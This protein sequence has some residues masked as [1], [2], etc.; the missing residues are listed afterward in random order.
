MMNCVVQVAKVKTVFVAFETL[1]APKGV[2]EF[3]EAWGLPDERWTK[4]VAALLKKEPSRRI[5]FLLAPVCRSSILIV[6]PRHPSH[7]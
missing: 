3:I 5:V 4:A 7:P 6:L 1:K 2:A